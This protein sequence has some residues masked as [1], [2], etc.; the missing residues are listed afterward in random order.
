MSFDSMHQAILQ[1]WP[2][3]SWRDKTVVVAVSGGADSTALLDALHQLRPDPKLTMVAHFNHAMRGQD[4]DADQMFVE[5]LANRLGF[6]FVV[7]KAVVDA[8]TNRSEN[9]LRNIRHEFLKEVATQHRARWIALAHHSDDQVET[10]LHNL[11]RG[12]GPSGL[13]G[14]SAIREINSMTALVRPMLHVTRSQILAYLSRRDQPFRVDSSNNSSVYTRNRIRNELLPLLRT[15]AGSESVDA[16]LRNACE[17]IGEE[18]AVVTE[19][20]RRWL[21]NVGLGEESKGSPRGGVSIPLELC[22]QESW[23]VIR[24]A[25]SIL[26]HR[27]GWP[28]REMSHTHWRR[29]QRMIEIASQS[30]HP[31]KLE[32]PGGICVRCC[33]GMLYLDR[34]LEELD[35]IL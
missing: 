21:T 31:K 1:L 4:S 33:K 11:L 5:S 24:H 6:E 14:M 16:R 25:V 3:D 28:M 10:F 34:K 32:L 20:A 29:L 26:W 2:M 30:T 13:A 19:M 17:L 15:F 9:Q 23:P 22:S 18:H 27:F 7:Q 35:N 12:S 8:T